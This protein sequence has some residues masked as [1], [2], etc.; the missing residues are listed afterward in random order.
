M[1]LVLNAGSSSV[2]Y[3]LFEITGT[4]TAEQLCS[5]LVEKIGLEMGILNHQN[6]GE[7]KSTVEMPF[8]DHAVALNKVIELLTDSETGKV[9]DLSCIKVAG[10]R[11]VHGGE[12][13]SEATVIND[14]TMAAIKE[15]SALAPLH[16]PAN[17]TGIEVAT[18]LFD[19]P[20]VSLHCH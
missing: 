14:E 15:A 7:E 2:K 12:K 10:H 9:K 8:P 4:D 16:N 6:E 5:G 11:V 13:F 19:C 20:Q 17:I 1:C 18:K 3:A